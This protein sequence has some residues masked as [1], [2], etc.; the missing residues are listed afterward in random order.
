M[1]EIITLSFV[2][3]GIQQEILKE[4]DLN[5]NKQTMWKIKIVSQ[6]VTNNDS[7]TTDRWW[8]PLKS[9]LFVVIVVDS[10]M[11]LLMFPITVILVRYYRCLWILNLFSN[12]GEKLAGN[13]SFLSQKISITSALTQKKHNKKR[14]DVYLKVWIPIW[15]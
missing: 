10:K 8:R 11:Y 9:K 5:S 6:F 1:I 15:K 12:I 2:N 4:K 13:L 3:Y 7:R 14:F